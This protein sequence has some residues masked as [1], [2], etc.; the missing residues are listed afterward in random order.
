MNWTLRIGSIQQRVAWDEGDLSRKLA[1]QDDRRELMDQASVVCGTM[2]T[3]VVA[4]HD[5]NLRNE[6]IPVPLTVACHTRKDA[7]EIYDSTG[8][9]S[10]AGRNEEHDLT[11]A[12]RARQR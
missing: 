9:E 8:P 10:A 12:V 2:I 5:Q 4:K 6:A 1:G 11:C 3:L 7:G